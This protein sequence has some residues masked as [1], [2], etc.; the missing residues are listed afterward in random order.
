MSASSADTSPLKE[1]KRHSEPTVD[2]AAKALSRFEEYTRCRDFKAFHYEQAVAFKRHLTE[3]KAVRRL[4]L[5]YTVLNRFGPREKGV[6]FGGWHAGP[7]A[8]PKWFRVL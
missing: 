7:G 8:L 4:R 2:A 6:H 1:A 5:V 3:E